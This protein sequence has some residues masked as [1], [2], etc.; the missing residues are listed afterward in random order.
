MGLQEILTHIEDPEEI[1]QTQLEV[2]DPTAMMDGWMDGW[3]HGMDGW[4]DGWAG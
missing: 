2:G 3:M 1:T 4:M